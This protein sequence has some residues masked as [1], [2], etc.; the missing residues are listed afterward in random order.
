LTDKKNLFDT[1]FLEEG[2]FTDLENIIK[3][4][5][6]VSE[7]YLFSETARYLLNI[8]IIKKESRTMPRLRSFLSRTQFGSIVVVFN[9]VGS[10]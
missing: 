8:T 1:L 9:P 10:G 2:S 5:D 3:M 4:L 7:N 6:I